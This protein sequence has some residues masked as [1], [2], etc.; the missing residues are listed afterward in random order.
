ML[1]PVSLIAL[2]AGL[3][4]LWLLLLYTMQRSMMFPGASMALPEQPRPADVTSLWLSVGDSRV[5]AWWMPPP[6]LQQMQAIVIHAHGN[7][8]LIDYS[9]M[10]AGRLRELGIGVLAVEYPGYGR[11]NGAPSQQSIT[12]TMNAAFDRIPALSGNRLLPVIGYGRSLGGGA[13]GQLAAHRRLDAL[14][15]E[16]TFSSARAF[17]SR[18]LAPGALMRDPFDTATILR[19]FTGA[20][21][22]VHGDRDEIIPY[23]HSDALLAAAP[24]ARRLTLACGHNDCPPDMNDYLRQLANFLRDAGILQPS[25][26]GRTQ[27]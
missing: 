13:I 20:V 11:S 12:D 3:Y 15:L 23:R 21:L 8:E 22:I 19:Q 16:S 1:R 9:P 6:D 25:P 24:Q 4:L 17:A 5:E 14:I 26:A 10:L 18:Y 27:T 7:A 2:G